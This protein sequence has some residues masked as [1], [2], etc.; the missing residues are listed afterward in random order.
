MDDLLGLNNMNLE[1]SWEDE[2]YAEDIED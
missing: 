2:G 1:F